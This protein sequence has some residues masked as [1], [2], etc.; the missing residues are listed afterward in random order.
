MRLDKYLAQ[1]TGYSRKEVKIWLKQGQVEIDGEVVTSAAAKV[2]D[3]SEV[4]LEGQLLAAPSPVYLMLNKPAG[5]VCANDDPTHPTV[6]SLIER[7]R[8]D[9]LMICGRLDLDTTGLVLLTSDGNWC[10][11]V[12]SPKHHT[13]KI[14]RVTTARPIDPKMAARFERGLMLSGDRERTKPAQLV[15]IDDFT[16]DVHLTEGRYH[17]VKRMFAAMEN[18]VEELHRYQIGS[19]LLDEWLEPGEYRDLTPEEVESIYE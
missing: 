3:G 9:E 10:H 7:V 16:C 5:V 13:T 8:A 4:T 12:I 14:Y 18:H 6:T 11:R 15:Q 19:I 2:P 1:T 17:Q